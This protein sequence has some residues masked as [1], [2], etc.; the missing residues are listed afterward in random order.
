MPDS[1]S[2]IGLLYH[3]TSD[4]GLQGI[5]ESDRI[6]ATHVRFLNDY[7]EFR[8]AFNEVYVEALTEAFREGLPT[9]IDSMARSV[10]DGLLSNRNRRSILKIIEDSGLATDAFV[11]SFTTLPQPGPDPGDR[12]SQWRGYSHST[13]GFSLGFDKVLL[14]NQIALDNPGAKA[15]VLECIYEDAEKLSFFQDMGQ[16]ACARF[17]ER[18]LQRTEPVPPG[19]TTNNPA[20]T[21]DYMKASSYFLKSLSEATAKFFTTAARIKDS[22][23]RE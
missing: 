22:G 19:F 3:Y 20:A 5:I 15:S 13:Q 2:A 23:F 21:E 14:E 1:A 9:D 10:I 18:W 12:L 4:V 8:Q 6:W 7:T 17:N 16:N 11:C